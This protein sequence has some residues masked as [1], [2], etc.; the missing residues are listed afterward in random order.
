[1]GGGGLEGLWG[2]GSAVGGGG[3]PR[4]GGLRATHNN[5]MHTSRGDVSLGRVWGSCWWL[6]S[7]TGYRLV[8]V[9][10]VVVVIFTSQQTAFV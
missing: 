4:W 1:M 7:S 2:G 9:S 8:G 3:F 10:T 5:H 6:L